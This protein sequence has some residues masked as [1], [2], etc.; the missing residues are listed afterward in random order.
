MR[1]TYLFL[2][3]LVLSCGEQEKSAEN[4]NAA[5]ELKACEEN[6]AQEERLKQ[7]AYDYIEA[8]N[9]ADW[10]TKTLKY[11]KPNPDKF[12]EGHGAFRESLPDCKFTIKRVFVEGN[13][14]ILWLNISATYT[15]TFTYDGHFE[16][17]K[18]IEAKGQ[19]LSWDET[20]YFNV[21]D[22]I[23][24][25]KWESLKDNY[26]ILEDLEAVPSS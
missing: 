13:E 6:E 16:P 22:G 8:A 15:S 11:L 25:D 23:F 17:F 2:T 1:L 9:A 18:D 10:K 12:L 20:W 19:P 3:F 21:E 7:W 4:E 24:G 26:K 5:S 14:I